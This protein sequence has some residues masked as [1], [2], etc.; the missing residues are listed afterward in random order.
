MQ[1]TQLVAGL[2][3]KLQQPLG[4]GRPASE[5]AIVALL[6]AMDKIG[7]QTFVA[8]FGVHHDNI[9][10]LVRWSEKYNHLTNKLEAISSAPPAKASP[11]PDV[12]AARAAI[13][14]LFRYFGANEKR[15]EMGVLNVLTRSNPELGR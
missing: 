7:P 10:T 11:R 4:R 13:S 1:N 8:Q 9:P 12:E 6:E 3:E 5:K 15:A 2:V 14:T